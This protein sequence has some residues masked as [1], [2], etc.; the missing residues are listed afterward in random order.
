[1][2]S[3]VNRPF[4][5]RLLWLMGAALV[6]AG[7]CLWRYYRTDGPRLFVMADVKIGE[8][9]PFELPD[10]NTHLVKIERYRSRQSVI[11]VFFDGT[12]PPQDNRTL[13]WLRD[14]SPEL[15]SVGYEV[16]GISAANPAVIRES[17]QSMGQPWPFPILSDMNPRS[18][19]LLPAHKSWGRFDVQTQTPLTGTFIVNQAGYTP[20]DNGHPQPLADPLPVLKALLQ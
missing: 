16:L 5:R 13:V 9:P 4:D 20:F 3:A 17:E 2:S 1:M 10:Q 15:K 11:V 19:E 7:L 14:N 18:P 6:I 12:A 8:A